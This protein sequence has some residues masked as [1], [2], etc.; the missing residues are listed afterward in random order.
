MATGGTLR[1]TAKMA[2]DS[3]IAVEIADT[4]KGIPADIAANIFNP[5]YTTKATGTGLGLAVVQK[6]LE[7]HH[8]E[9]KMSSAVGQGSVFT[10]LLPQKDAQ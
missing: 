3:R 8:G 10:L 4:G 9:I 5:Y 7:D 6:I 1:V 2:D